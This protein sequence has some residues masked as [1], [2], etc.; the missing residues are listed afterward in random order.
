MPAYAKT[1]L[2]FHHALKSDIDVYARPLL[3]CPPGEPRLLLNVAEAIIMDL[4]GTIER[5]SRVLGSDERNAYHAASPAENA[6]PTP[7]K[8]P[9]DRAC[10]W[11]QIH[12][13]IPEDCTW[14]SNVTGTEIP[15]PL[16]KKEWLAKLKLTCPC[17]PKRYGKKNSH[18]M[19]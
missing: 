13:I 11:S 8:Q 3:I 14:L 12:V 18:S 6:T 1:G 16:S 10:P 4:C 2:L 17:C 15:F 19:F 7:C 9:L 5:D